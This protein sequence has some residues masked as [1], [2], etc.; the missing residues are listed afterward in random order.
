VNT[1]IPLNTLAISLGSAGLAETWG[2]AGRTLG[3]SAVAAEV[4][5]G[6]AAAVWLAMIAAHA[7]RGARS[8]ET[9]ASQL[10]NPAQGPIAAVWPIVGMALGSTL[11]EFWPVGGDVLIIASFI[12]STLF[13]AWLLAHLMNGQLRL[14]SIHGGYFLPIAAAA[15]VAAAVLPSAGLANVAAGCFSV[16]VFFWIVTFILLFA[17]LA[18]RE[19]LAA[20][21]F[22]TLAIMTAPPAVAGVAWI[23]MNG[24]QPSA[25]D[26]WL[27]AS[28]VFMLLVQLAF[29]PRYVKL[30]FTLGFWSFTFPFAYS[31]VYAI[32]WLG[33]LRPNGW[34]AAAIAVLAVVTALV[35]TIATKSIALAVHHRR[36]SL[37]TADVQLTVADQRI[38]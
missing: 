34:H 31:G 15:F 19:P 25:V 12:L 35:G 16:G 29:L 33:I 6:I 21:L 3:W 5:W 8:H 20:P 9:L 17:R 23:A 28:M 26:Y 37:D 32:D 24:D 4:F 1:R 2:A 11:H 18:F 22:P 14:E 13:G 7:V 36:H 38:S 27:A 30:P 10:R